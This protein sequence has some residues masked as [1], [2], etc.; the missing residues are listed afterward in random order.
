MIEFNTLDVGSIELLCTI[1]SEGCQFEISGVC[2]QCGA[3][4]CKN[5]K[6]RTLNPIDYLDNK[7]KAIYCINCKPEDKKE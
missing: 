3:F 4:L 7:P 5:S 6:C 2:S 1:G